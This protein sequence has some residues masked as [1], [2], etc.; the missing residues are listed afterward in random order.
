MVK[1]WFEQLSVPER[2]QCITT[3]DVNI[4]KSIRYMHSQLT[5]TSNNETGKFKMHSQYSSS[6]SCSVLEKGKQISD[7]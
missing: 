6:Y 3:I 5:K 7:L 2:V 4:T 1:Q